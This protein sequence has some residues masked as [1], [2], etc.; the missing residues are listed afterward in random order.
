MGKGIL[1]KKESGNKY[2]IMNGEKKK[3]RIL[4]EYIPLYPGQPGD[5]RT[6]QH[7]LVQDLIDFR[8]PFCQQQ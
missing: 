6:T 4:V 8:A 3:K 5:Q 7:I 2:P 1:E